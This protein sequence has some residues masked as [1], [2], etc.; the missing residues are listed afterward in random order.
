MEMMCIKLEVIDTKYE[1]SWKYVCLK[2]SGDAE[3]GSRLKIKECSIIISNQWYE[4]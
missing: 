4:K 1:I 2:V 3:G